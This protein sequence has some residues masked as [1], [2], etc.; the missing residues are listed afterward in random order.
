MVATG[1]TVAIFL[2]NEKNVKPSNIMTI[3]FTNV[4][5]KWLS[6]EQ[7]TVIL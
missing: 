2:L 3:T 1:A 4:E 6:Q 7:T 5:G